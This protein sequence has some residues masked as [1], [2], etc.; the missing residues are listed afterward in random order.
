MPRRLALFFDGTWNDPGDA[1]DGVAAPTNVWRL[2]SA[3][4]GTRRPWRFPAGMRRSDGEMHVAADDG[5]DQLA[6]YH[7]GVG[8]RGFW[9]RLLGGAG[10]AGLGDNV[11]DGY[12]WLAMTWRPGDEIHLYGFSRGAYT[13][14]SLAGMIRK[15]GLPAPG[16]AL[17]A[18]R[19]QR[20]YD[21][22]RDGTHPDDGRAQAFRREQQGG[23][24]DPPPIA[25]IG[26]FDTVGCLGIPLRLAERWNLRRY[27][28]HDTRLS[29]WVLNAY[30]AVA[31]DEQRPQYTAT[32]WADDCTARLPPRPDLSLHVEQRWFAGAHCN[33]GGGYADQRLADLALAWIAGKAAGHGLALACPPPAP[34]A[35][36]G[37][38]RDSFPEFL[39]RWGNWGYALF[40]RRTP[41]P[42]RPGVAAQA[43]DASVRDRRAAG[44]GYAP[45]NLPAEAGER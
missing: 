38:M 33:V 7:D 3:L 28:F 26:V 1:E 17:D 14:R 43:V 12:A 11:V 30:H 32:L 10:G 24:A 20:A 44:L 29:N 45:P 5:G 42:I 2:F 6:W 8:T 39:G 4:A 19:F 40:N 41:R 27:Q 22:Y 23:A 37:I 9:D 18:G 35:C 13:A 21:F 25:V 36:R 31:V 16:M 34:G 15:C